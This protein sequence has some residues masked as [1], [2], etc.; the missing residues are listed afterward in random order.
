MTNYG[1]PG[2]MVSPRASAQ[3]SSLFPQL[4][5]IGQPAGP[6][7][8]VDDKTIRVFPDRRANLAFSINVIGSR[9]FGIQPGQA[10]I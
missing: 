9:R 4:P 6:R 3:L 5:I 7:P 10:S 1:T 2:V 8:V